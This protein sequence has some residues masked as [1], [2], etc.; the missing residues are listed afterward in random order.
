MKKY[1][2]IISSLILCINALAQET[3]YPAPAHNG[4]LFIK[5]ATVHTGTGQVLANTSILINN[6]KIEKIG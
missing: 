5:D 6:G 1:T 3:I 4:L 2:T